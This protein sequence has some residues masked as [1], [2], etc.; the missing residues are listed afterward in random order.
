MAIT[1]FDPVL[2]GVV[3]DGEL[4]VGLALLCHLLRG[5]LPIVAARDRVSSLF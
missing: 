2:V 4:H 1:V 3:A 5:E